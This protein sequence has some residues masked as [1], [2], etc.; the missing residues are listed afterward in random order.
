MYLFFEHSCSIVIFSLYKQQ[1][2]NDEYPFL[3]RIAAH[4]LVNDYLQ[5]FKVELPHHAMQIHHD[6]LMPQFRDQSLH[7]FGIGLLVYDASEALAVLAAHY[8]IAE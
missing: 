4:H 8:P 1:F 3:V 2:L 5:R 7:E 6:A